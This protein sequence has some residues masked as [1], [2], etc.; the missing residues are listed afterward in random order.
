MNYIKY[1]QLSCVFFILPLFTIQ[2]QN[3][4]QLYENF[5]IVSIDITSFQKDTKS[6]EIDK[7][8]PIK[9]DRFLMSFD[10][11]L[12]HTHLG[13]QRLKKN[14][15][16]AYQFGYR[17]NEKTI[18]GIGLQVLNEEDLIQIFDSN[19]LGTQTFYLSKAQL[20]PFARRYFRTIKDLQL[21]SQIGIELSYENFSEFR[22]YIDTEDLF[23]DREFDYLTFRANLGLGL[24]FHI[25]D[26]LSLYTYWDG[27]T[28]G[29]NIIQEESTSG[30]MEFGYDFDTNSFRNL[31]F[32]IKLNF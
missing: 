32:G 8:S 3:S 13:F 7:K 11:N 30:N 28:I 12:S 24:E 9:L 17:A 23:T 5:N 16:I 21:Y 25:K 1:L 31:R 6:N 14:Q 26:D 4:E 18:F 15:S 22:N 10:G 29:R 27:L 2:A 20:E 19:G